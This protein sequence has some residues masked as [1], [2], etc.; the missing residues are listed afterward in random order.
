MQVVIHTFFK[1]IEEPSV[2]EGLIRADVIP[3][4][5]DTPKDAASARLLNSLL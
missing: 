3:F 1:N 2:S 5:P 4:L